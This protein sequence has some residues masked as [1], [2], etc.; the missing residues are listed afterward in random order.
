[1]ESQDQIAQTHFQGLVEILVVRDQ[2]ERQV[3]LLIVKNCLFKNKITIFTSIFVFQ[4]S[5]EKGVSQ[6]QTL[7]SEVMV[8]T[9]VFQAVQACQEKGE[10]RGALDEWATEEI[11]V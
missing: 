11:W 9:M 4:G 1:M 3:R 7:Q 5:L 10:N 2:T 6:V 8:E